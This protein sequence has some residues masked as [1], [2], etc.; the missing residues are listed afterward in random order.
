M[1][2]EQPATGAG[3][4]RPGGEPSWQRLA[5]IRLAVVPLVLGP[6]IVPTV[7]IFWL[8]GARPGNGAFLALLITTASWLVLLVGASA[9]NWTS[10]RAAR[11]RV[12]DE[13]VELR[14][15]ILWR[16]HQSIR[17][18]RIRSVDVTASP[19]YRIFGIAVVRVGTGENVSSGDSE[20]KLNGVTRGH[21]DELRRQ[22]LR[23]T[24]AGRRE[25][26]RLGDA[27][28]ET[29]RLIADEPADVE[30]ARMQRS[31][32]RFAPLTLSVVLGATAGLL[33][34]VGDIFGGGGAGADT[35]L[36]AAVDV[37]GAIWLL[38]VS[39]AATALL[40]GFVGSFLLFVEAWSNFRLL[41][42]HGGTLRVTRGLLTTRSISLE[43]SR[44]R[45]AE[46]AEPL[47]VRWAGGARVNAVATGLSSKDEAN[48]AADRKALLPPAPRAAAY[49]VAA[50]VIGEPA[51]TRTR[52]T[53]H[54]HAALRR[55]LMWA[56]T[57]V[58]LLMAALAVLG[59]LFTWM[60]SWVWPVVLPLLP[61]AAV[62][63]VDAF[64]ALGH[65]VST[66]HLVTR[67][68][69][70]IRRTIALRR[71]GIIG[72]NVTQSPFQRRA[73]LVTVAATAAAGSGA[74]KIRDAAAG[75]ALALADEA[76]PELLRPFL[77]RRQ[78]GDED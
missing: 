17:R 1:S 41:R 19:F 50:E 72:W 8:A 47:L 14:S 32:L 64:R 63:A 62:A 53:G 48:K 68:G 28:D 25:G 69:T 71:N 23:R 44:L 51:F 55:R 16:R 2:T 77:E 9:F 5:K 46:L 34:I 76:V 60:P 57:P 49:R 39:V 30:L 42:E 43:E 26:V 33:G 3:V 18:D 24:A 67:Y 36:R 12:T 52:L 11:H 27:A 22:L 61:V 20:L 45:G 15:G 59:Y 58:L 29:G 78:A 40:A 66:R 54:P 65:G 7:V 73:G 35:V 21:A 56:L 4:T 74:Y 13:H 75:E 31:W 37:V 6:L 10:W 38:V 70:G